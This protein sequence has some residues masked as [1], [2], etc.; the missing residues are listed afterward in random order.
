MRIRAGTSGFDYAAWKGSFYPDDLPAK[1]R[2]DYYGRNL[3]AVEINA[4]FY[5]MPKREVVRNWAAQ[6]PEDFAFVLKASRRITHFAKLKDSAETVEFL[7][8]S[9]SELGPRL[10]PILFQL[11]PTFKADAARLADFLAV[12][13]DGLRA[14]LEVRNPSWRCDEV[15]ELLRKHGVCL[16]VADSGDDRE[17]EIIPT[18]DFGYL[19]MRRD[20]YGDGDLERLAERI[21]AQP[22]NE[23]FVFFK[24]EDGG[25]APAMARRLTALFEP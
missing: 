1:K 14:V 9:A 23:C 19:R 21:G 5:R 17:P 13:P 16:C 7:W 6:V 3:S 11:P 24:H 12:L 8:K 10:G 18:A 2:L 22:W 25:V 20:D 4:T 15:Y